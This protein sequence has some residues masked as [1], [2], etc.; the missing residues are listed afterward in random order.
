MSEKRTIRIDCDVRDHLPLDQLEP[1]QGELKSLSK[2][3]YD[4]LR[5]EI[6]EHGFAFPVHVW[7][8]PENVHFILGGHQRVRV[9]KELR[10]SE[11][12]EIPPIPV[13]MVKAATFALAKRRVLQDASQYGKVEGQGLYQFMNEI[14][15][16]P[17]ELAMS[18]RL[19]E[20]NMPSFNAEFFFDDV[21]GG[22]PGEPATGSKELS[23]DDFNE[24]NHKC[25]RCGFHFDGQK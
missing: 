18:F 15:L 2:E 14:S 19:P 23:P 5:R 20:L 8:S 6:I 11:G 12:F 1:F 16:D 25:P 7:R 10:Q 21:V 9:L 17:G 13:V 4:R 24:F 22:E 3:D